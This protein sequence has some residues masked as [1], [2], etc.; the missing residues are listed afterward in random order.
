MEG[1]NARSWSF[2]DVSS[3]GLSALS[4]FFLVGL[5]VSALRNP[6]ANAD[7]IFR[8]GPLL[9]MIE[10]L[11]LVATGVLRGGKVTHHPSW[12]H[13]IF[14]RYFP[15][16]AIVTL[17]IM[18]IWVFNDWYIPVVF[19]ASFVA[20]HFW[21]RTSVREGLL[22]FSVVLLL[23]LLLATLFAAQILEKIFPFPPELRDF[24]PEIS[25]GSFGE[26][27]QTLLVW[28]ALYYGTLLTVETVLFF[29]RIRR[30]LK[31]RAASGR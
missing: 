1:M 11:S 19:I 31:T 27:P 15:L 30:H 29:N 28:G 12:G 2:G 23:I 9:V 5:F 6:L 26:S 20:K 7:F 18:L 4:G 8:I 22:A 16:G 24:Q 17:S 13:E 25:G 3:F 10:F 14:Y 21:T